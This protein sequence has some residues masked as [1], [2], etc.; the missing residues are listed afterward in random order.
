[1]NYHQLPCG[2]QIPPEGIEAW[3]LDSYG[4]HG[5]QKR[6]IVAVEYGGNSL[7]CASGVRWNKYRLTDPTKPKRRLV[8]PM[9]LAGK[10]LRSEKS[11]RFVCEVID[12]EINC[13]SMSGNLERIMQFFNGYSDTPTSEV[14]S[15][16]VED[17]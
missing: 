1:M 12:T 15:F 9:E 8:T 14:K 7:I 3:V 11:A 10:W 6:T 13:L 2:T 4:I 16:W 5:W 17:V